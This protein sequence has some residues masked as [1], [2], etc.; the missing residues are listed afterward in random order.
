M[1][2]V[3]EAERTT[4]ERL[5]ERSLRRG[6]L[7][8]ALASFRALSQA[9]PADTA[10]ATRL[11]SLE[12]A[13]HPSELTPATGA[14]RSAPSGG[15]TSP[16]HEAEARA[17][18]GDFDGA[19]GIYQRLLGEQPTAE[20]LVERLAELRQLASATRSHPAMSRE[21]LLE[22]LLERIAARRRHPRPP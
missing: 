15:Y 8:E 9:F 7:N 10:L 6:E 12:A 18:R 19:I 11:A 14:V 21:Q 5:A 17:A 1:G 4:L 13:V 16:A 20:L 3:N 2:F 22:H